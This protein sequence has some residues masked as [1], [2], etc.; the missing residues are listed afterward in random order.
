MLEYKIIKGVRHYRMS[1]NEPWKVDNVSSAEA[2]RRL[3]AQTPAPRPASQ[4]KTTPKKKT[5][6]YKKKGIFGLFGGR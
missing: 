5:Y 4:V 2:D 3:A 6:G 1:P